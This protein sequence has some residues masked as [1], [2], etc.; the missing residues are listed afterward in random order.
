M[1]TIFSNAVSSIQLGVEDFRNSDPRRVLSAARN[2]TAGLLLLYKEKLY[3]MSPTG[4]DGVL[5]KQDFM[6]VLGPDGTVTFAGSKK[7]TVDVAGIEARFKS[8]GIQVDWNSVRRVT[9]LRNDMEHHSTD[10]PLP[11]VRE[12]IAETF[13]LIG[14]F[15]KTE[16]D[17]V[18]RDRFGPETWDYMFEQSK[19]IQQDQLR[20]RQALAKIAWP[21]P[22]LVKVAGRIECP[23]CGS[24]LMLAL[25][26]AADIPEHEF[27][28]CLC[29]QRSDFE[30]V[31]EAAVGV[32][33]SGENYVDI[34][35]GG[36]GVTGQCDNCDRDTYL[37]SAGMCLAC[38]DKPKKCATC[39][40]YYGRFCERCDAMDSMGPEE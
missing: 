9:G 1:N 17:E 5:I 30:E 20:C 31:A 2:I 36:E 26:P 35:D 18:P 6:P 22:E 32:A 33:Y 13:V 37:W 25:D 40:S 16:L 3:R 38:G 8:L 21:T 4:S 10:Q 28:C 29:G 24:S 34:K 39:G 11:V 15:C 7:K 23:K 12:L 19:L 14:T 27:E